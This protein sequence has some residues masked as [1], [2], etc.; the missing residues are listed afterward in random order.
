MKTIA[1]VKELQVTE[2]PLVLF[3]CT[4]PSGRVE[5]WSTHAV[6][7]NGDQYDARVLRH[8]SFDMKWGADDGIDTMNK[9]SLVLANADSHFSQIFTTIGFKGATLRATFLFFDLKTGTPASESMAVFVGQMNSPEEVTESTIRLTATSRLNFQRTYLPEIRIQR[10]CP[11]MFPNNAEQREEARTGSGNGR[12]SAIYRCGYST[13]QPG[14]LGNLNSGAPF[15]HCDYTRAG[16]IERGMFDRDSKGQ[17]TRRFGGIEFVPASILVRSHGDKALSASALSE[18]EARYNDYV[19]VVYGTC[20][21]QPPMVFARND[22]NL[23]RIEVLLGAGEIEGVLKVVVNDIEIP[24][25]ISGKNMTGT[26]WYN[27][28]SHGAVS[29]GF[30]LDFTDSTGRPLGDPYGSLAYMSI[31]VPNRVSDGKTLPKVTVLMEGLKLAVFGDDGS[32]IGEQFT[33][34][35]AWVIL[36]LLRRAGWRFDEIDVSSFSKSSAFAA[37][38]IEIPDLNGNPQLRPR[39]QCNLALRRRRAVADVI[40]GVRNASRM[41]LVINQN[42]R[43]ALRVEGTFAL[44]Q[45][46]R[47]VGTNAQQKLNGGWPAYEFGDGTDGKSG[48]VRKPNGQSSVTLWAR[49]TAECANRWSVEFQD[50]F[51]EYQQ[52]SLSLVDVDDVRAIRQE[53]SATSTALGVTNFHQAARVLRLQLNK[54]LKGNIFLSFQTSVRGVCLRPGDLITITYQ[55]EGLIRQPFRVTR[56]APTFLDGTILVEAQFHDD[57]WYGDDPE[58]SVSSRVSRRPAGAEVGLPRPLLGNEMDEDGNPRNSVHEAGVENGDGSWTTTL[59]VGYAVPRKPAATGLDIPF[60]SLRPIIHGTN[61]ALKGGES[62][63][64]AIS[65]V[66]SSGDETDLS[67]VVRAI[68]PHGSNTNSVELKDLSFSAGTATFH[69]YRGT[70]PSELM[71]VASNVPIAPQY[72]D[73]GTGSELKAPPDENFDHAIVEWRFELLPETAASTFGPALIGG[74]DLG[75]SVDEFSGMVVRITKGRGAGQERLIVSNTAMSFN[76]AG[77]WSVVPDESSRFVVAEAGWKTGARASSSPVRF[78]VPSRTGATVQLCGRAVNAIGRD[79][80]YET[81]LVTRWRLGSGPAGVGDAD[82]PPMPSFGLEPTGQGSLNLVSVGFATLENTR[83]VNSATIKLFFVDELGGAPLTAL[84]QELDSSAVILPSIA[85]AV[86][87]GGLLLLDREILEVDT[88]DEVAGTVTVLRGSH[89]TS[90]VV[91]AARTPIY[92][93]QYRTWVVPFPSD[94]FGSPASGSFTYQISLP[95]CKVVAANLHATNKKGNGETRRTNYTNSTDAGLR[96]L[97]GGQIT[98]Q[99]EGHLAIQTDAT[100]PFVVE[101]SHSIRDIFA[102]VREAPVGGAIELTI[103]QGSEALTTLTI[104]S[105]ETMSNIVKGA[106]VHPLT[107]LAQLSVDIVSIPQGVDVRPGRD[108]TVAIRL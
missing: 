1:E 104:Q 35:P 103:R 107:A 13:D 28:V 15:T 16:C 17:V 73:P 57:G 29:G 51:N 66:A 31:V 83:T 79:S 33:N 18:N 97:S 76:I 71:R 87:G 41:F 52:D 81:A 37:E 12:H 67:F 59:A 93:L 39:F 96:T 46:D 22:G 77:T 108:L 5:H 9:V 56:L 11:W 98:L 23:T 92:L 89:G 2:T 82:V 74:T 26:G 20:W 55:K 99:V 25:G 85:G 54:A 48:I 90:A 95:D 44:Q 94:F 91:H 58:A 34:N 6:S 84:E 60:L 102:M 45:G 70:T 72:L 101:N 64:Y 3:D 50:S 86:S 40:R 14:G 8:S 68:V 24:V 63:Y 7:A 10:R 36:D 61:G 27:V 75:L 19:P 32:Y 53:L 47:Q 65:G 43:L 88:I 42:G 49:G 21:I 30:N 80:G 106:G 105:G 62:Y 100:P 69:V 4:W 38:P 78:V